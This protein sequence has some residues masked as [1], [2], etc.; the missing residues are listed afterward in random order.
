M[1]TRDNYEIYFLDYLEGG[2]STTLR[3]ELQLFLEENPDLKAEFEAFDVVKVPAESVAY[4]G[5][6]DLKKFTEEELDEPKVVADHSIVYPYKHKLRRGGIVIPLWTRVV[7]AAVIV[8]AA[9][10]YFN[11]SDSNHNQLVSSNTT[12]QQEL[13]KANDATSKKSTE[14]DVSIPSAQLVTVK[15]TNKQTVIKTRVEDVKQFAATPPEDAPTNVV[16]AA[17]VEPQPTATLVEEVKPSF[18]VFSDEELVEIAKSSQQPDSGEMKTP[19]L[20]KVLQTARSL[21]GVNSGYTADHEREVFAL[22]SV[23]LSRNKK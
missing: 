6:T 14:H 4:T 22:G 5:K 18:T 10:V 17:V 7:A 8:F 23:R 11:Q 15:R 12:V 19:A 1:I 2:L 21:F 20:G 9:L 3:E 13:P 16:P